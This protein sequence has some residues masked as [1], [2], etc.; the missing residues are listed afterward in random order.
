MMSGY[1]VAMPHTKACKLRALAVTSPRRAAIFPDVPTIAE[2]DYPAYALDTW[3]G[4][5]VGRNAR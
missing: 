1:V 4:F 3:A 2:A 5:R